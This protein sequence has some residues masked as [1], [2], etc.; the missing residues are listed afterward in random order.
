[1][2]LSHIWEVYT[3]P[4]GT[5]F[6]AV[7]ACESVFGNTFGGAGWELY[8]PRYPI[9]RQAVRQ[10]LN[11][12]REIHHNLFDYMVMA[13]CGYPEHARENYELLLE[14][15]D[16]PIEIYRGAAAIRLSMVY[17]A[18][19]TDVQMQKLNDEILHWLSQSLTHKNNTIADGAAIAIG[20]I[21]EN[22]AKT[23]AV[24]ND[25]ARLLNRVTDA[26]VAGNVRARLEHGQRE[27]QSVKLPRL[28]AGAPQPLSFPWRICLA[29]KSS[30]PREL[31]FATASMERPL[32]S[33]ASDYG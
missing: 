13:A 3:A 28:E 21:A 6:E 20:Y 16:G 19:T 8:P 22:Y 10:V 30:P 5:S 27:A 24:P 26:Q 9:L 7:Q 4:R 31:P 15:L 2:V 32:T 23:G 11:Q 14:I 33:P 18:H 12:R 17:Q 29:K 25:V 1:M